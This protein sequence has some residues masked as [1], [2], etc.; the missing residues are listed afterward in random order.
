MGAQGRSSARSQRPLGET[1]RVPAAPD[2]DA[3]G[4]GGGV[5]AW[6]M[7][8]GYRNEV[9]GF[10][11]GWSLRKPPKCWGP[12][13]EGEEVNS[14]PGTRPDGGGR[15][16]ARRCQLAPP[17]R[18]SRPAGLLPGA[19]AADTGCGGGE[20]AA[21]DR[22]RRRREGGGGETEKRAGAR[23]SPCGPRPGGA[24]GSSRRG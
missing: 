18:G 20:A 8:V 6:G 17:S 11:C 4:G 19:G 21:R 15:Q 1:G 16:E 12:G 24:G 23:G 2:S 10:L 13:E 5:R 9:G 7:G 22:S 14:A 3:A